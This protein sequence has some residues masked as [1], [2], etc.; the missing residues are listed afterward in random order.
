M[1]EIKYVIEKGQDVPDDVIR[2]MDDEQDVWRRSE[3]DESQWRTVEMHGEPCTGDWTPAN[4]MSATWG[5]LTV[6]AVREP[7]PICDAATCDKPGHRHVDEIFPPEPERKLIGPPHAHLD[8]PCTDKCYEPAPAD[9]SVLLDLVRQYGEEIGA[10][11]AASECAGPN[12][13]WLHEQAALA[14]LDRIAA[15]VPPSAPDFL[16]SINKLTIERDDARSERDQLMEALEGFAA[17]RETG[18]AEV[19]RLTEKLA[20]TQEVVNGFMRAP[21]PS[22]LSLPQVPDGAVALVGGRRWVRSERAPEKWKLADGPHPHALAGLGAVLDTEGP[23]TVVMR[24]PRTWP[25]LDGAPEDV[26]AAKGAS[27]NVWR[28]SDG[29]TEPPLWCWEDESSNRHGFHPFSLVQQLD[30][31]LTEVFEDETGGAA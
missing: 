27:G 8:A 24:E 28:P 7:D 23:V 14:I 5:P 17:D 20:A 4:V 31:P 6:T 22:V 15:L 12:D 21:D 9:V 2:V 1:T 3:A 16:A 10:S 29:V 30:G 19:E 13:V 25:R 26:K 11:V 18:R